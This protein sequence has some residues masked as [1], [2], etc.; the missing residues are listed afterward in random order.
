MVNN[1]IINENEL[2]D[3]INSKK[4]TEYNNNIKAFIKFTF[5]DKFNLQNPKFI[6]KKIRGGPKPD[7]SITHNREEKFISVKKGSGN[8][9]HQEKIDTFFPYFEDFIGKKELNWLKLFHYGDDTIDGSGEIRYNA[10][11]C[12]KRYKKEIQSLN[13]QINKSNYLE[14]FLDRFLFVGNVSELN[15]DVIYHGTIN[16]GLWA[17]DKEIKDYIKNN[18]FSNN[19]IHFGPLT[20]QVWGRD[21]KRTAKHPDRRYVMQ[22]KWGSI[23]SDLSSIREHAN[24][25]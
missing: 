2:I 16:S 22:I 11:E 20:Y 14:A 9:V 12:K 25:V 1:G 13:L 7:L 6:A 23:E 19:A 24:N 8:S 5:G 18:Y 17:S 3:Y 21:D 4:Y 10:S 15:V